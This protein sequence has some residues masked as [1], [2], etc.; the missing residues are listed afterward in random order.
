M[1]GWFDKGGLVGVHLVVLRYFA[2]VFIIAWCSHPSLF[3]DLNIGD[4]APDFF[5]PGVDGKNYSLKDFEA[6][7]VL[8]V[9]FTCNHCPTAQAYEDRL[10]A[11]T[12]EYKS[13]KVALVAISPN[14]PLA[15]RKDELGYSAVED[16]FE[17]MR[18][19][20]S[21]KGF[22][23]PYLY[24]GKDQNCS[25]SYGPRV[26]PQVFVF[27]QERLLR[28]AGRIDNGANAEKV[29]R[30]DLRMAIDHLLEGTAIR[31]NKTK[32][33]G[34]SI[35]WSE[36]RKLAAKNLALLD[37]ET[38]SLKQLDRETLDFHLA[39]K[40]QL[41]KLFFIWSP[42]QPG[43]RESFTQLVEVHRRFRKR[44]VEIITIA[45]QKH[46]VEEKLMLD[47]LQR[48]HAS[49]RNYLHSG[50]SDDLL[51]KLNV[52]AETKLPFVMLVKPGGGVPL[53]QRGSPLDTLGLKR[54]ILNVIGRKYSP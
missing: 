23:F 51:R 39:N 4:S 12:R 27:G 45:S 28:Y 8:V 37:R 33:L 46:L 6:A 41:L 34:C 42:A 24:D 16:T 21:Q 49:C 14:D 2:K 18:I 19:R 43:I 26:T 38:V 15:F 13:S 52:P 20:A 5:L 29:Y 25:R 11:I 3:A 1:V 7:R 17:G 40:S 50:S 36:G 35:K 9:V 53:Y 47:F 31:S 48:Q 54:S 10:I 30:H 22:P 32:V 44:G